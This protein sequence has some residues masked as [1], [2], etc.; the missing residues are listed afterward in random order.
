MLSSFGE[1]LRQRRQERGLQQAELAGKV[2][3]TASYV[4]LLESGK[5]PAPSPQVA[6]RMEQALGLE[7]ND[8]V[9]LAHL[10]RTPKDI[11]DEMDLDRLYRQGI[12]HKGARAVEVEGPVIQS[13]RRIP[14]INR[15]SAGYPTD[16][17]DKGYPVGVADEY[18]SIPDIDDPNAFAIMVSGDSM[19]P[20]FHEGDVLIVS[21]AEPVSNGDVCFVRIDRAGESSSTIKQVWFDDELS[22]RLESLN[23]KYAS[24]V[25]PKEDIGGVYRA[26]RRVEKL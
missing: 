19:E 25:L 15:V 21:P 3:V 7:P 6:A 16:F 24:Q 10:E 20:R 17:S 4:S 5:R 8:L 12:L 2:G 11:R 1:K 13:I 14:L 22:V 18:V 26:V 9:R 23:R